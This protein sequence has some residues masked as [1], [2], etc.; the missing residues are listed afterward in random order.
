MRTPTIAYLGV[1]RG[2]RSPRKGAVFIFPMLRA[3]KDDRGNL[4][5]AG[6]RATPSRRKSKGALRDR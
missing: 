3:G 4:R 1:R 2:R 6:A 5:F